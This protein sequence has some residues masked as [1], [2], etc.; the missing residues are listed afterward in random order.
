MADYVRMHVPT[1]NPQ[2]AD[3]AAITERLREA[4]AKSGGP[5]QVS[6]RSKVALGT[7]NGYLAGGDMKLSNLVRLAQACG[8][9]VEWLATG[10]GP[11]PRWERRSAGN[12][13]LSSAVQAPLA[14]P[15]ID[16]RLLAKAIEIVDSLGG[17]SLSP[18][19]RAQRIAH[20]YDL[21]T[22]PDTDLPPLPQLPTRRP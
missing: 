4:V 8:V 12:T 1:P 2:P 9:S 22:A 5:G 10:G 14:P 19:E 16:A 20:S 13:G 7:L 15:R 11:L 21:L 6:S 18:H 3:R 17:A